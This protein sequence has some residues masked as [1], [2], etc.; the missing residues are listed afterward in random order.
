MTVRPVGGETVVS[1]ARRFSAANEL[2]PT[3]ILRAL[4]HLTGN[5]SGKHLLI[6]DAWL[7][8]QAIGRLEAYTGIPRARLAW[9]LPALRWQMPP[10]RRC[11]RTGQPSASAGRIPGP[12]A[13]AR[14]N[15][16]DDHADGHHE[17]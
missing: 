5:G 16:R 10:A 12:G 11:R 14:K 17:A 4:G 3:A 2:P 13:A 7:N 9:T 8:E 15:K 6:C 1:Y